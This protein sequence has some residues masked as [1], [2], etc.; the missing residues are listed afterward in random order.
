MW[1][2]EERLQHARVGHL[3]VVLPSEHRDS[4]Y[5]EGTRMV[6][7]DF[8]HVPSGGATAV[9]EASIEEGRGNV[10]S[11]GVLPEAR[12]AA[13]ARQ[14]VSTGTEFAALMSALMSDV[15]EGRMSPVVSNAAVSAGRNLLKVVEMEYKYGGLV[16]Q[17]QPQHRPSIQLTGK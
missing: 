14:G 6:S 10:A 12:S 4:E 11:N 13:L 1:R 5:G 15:I 16:E 3:L 9:A 7:Q 17:P 2:L 8:D